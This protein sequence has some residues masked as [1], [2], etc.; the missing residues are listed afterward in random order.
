[1]QQEPPDHSGE[2]QAGTSD[3]DSEDVPLP[4]ELD[5]ESDLDDSAA[6]MGESDS[7]ASSGDVHSLPPD[8]SDGDSDVGADSA[9][10]SG[11]QTSCNLLHACL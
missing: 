4:G 9:F 7:A 6:A 10:A 3:S 11:T 2:S 8:V 5:D 1:M